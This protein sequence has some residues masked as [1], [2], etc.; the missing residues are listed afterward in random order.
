MV[1]TTSAHVEEAAPASVIHPWMEKLH[2][3][4]AD[5]E[6][7]PLLGDGAPVMVDG[8]YQLYP[9]LLRRDVT[10]LIGWA[11]QLDEFPKSASLTRVEFGGTP[12]GLT[13]VSVIGVLLGEVVELL[14]VTHRPCTRTAGEVAWDELLALVDVERRDLEPVLA[15]V[16]LAEWDRE[17]PLFTGALA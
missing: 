8:R 5:A 10:A 4:A 14:A 15:D 9:Y 11:E 16:V 7:A 12:V 6:L 1:T 3:L 17:D 2:A 13:Q